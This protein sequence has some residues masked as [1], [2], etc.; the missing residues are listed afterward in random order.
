MGKLLVFGAALLLL[1]VFP[2][3]C[4][5]ADTSTTRGHTSPVA[6]DV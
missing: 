2:G 6:C 1:D 3:G 4:S 5:C